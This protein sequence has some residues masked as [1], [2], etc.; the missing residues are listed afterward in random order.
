MAKLVPL[1][2][3]EAKTENLSD[4]A[5]VAACATGDR[6]ALGALFDRHN[7]RVLRFAA[8]ML[9]SSAPE[10][11]DVVQLTFETVRRTAPKYRGASSVRTWIIG[12]AYNVIRRQY[13]KREQ[14]QR[15]ALA[16][17]SQPE[18]ASVTP[19]EDV[20][21]AEQLR[22]LSDAV[23]QLSPKLREVFVLAYVEGM[24]GREVAEA[25]HIR[26]GTVWKRLHA[27]RAKLRE[28][29]GGSK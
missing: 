2:R 19:L 9:G 10:V 14:S 20:S 16:V 29:I 7:E 5:L 6:A 3:V 26:E 21:R 22:R 8:R 4:E 24:S 18:P 28:T 13:R 11:D 25:L 12:I 23:D 17:A 15:V 27:A 1:R